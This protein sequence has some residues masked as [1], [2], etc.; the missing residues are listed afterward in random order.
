M[1]NI[2]YSL[3]IVNELPIVVYVFGV[4]DCCFTPS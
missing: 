2:Y 1:K 4:S 3:I